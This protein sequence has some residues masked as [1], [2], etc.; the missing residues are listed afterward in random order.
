MDE[1]IRQVM[2]DHYGKDDSR[3]Y[4]PDIY[5]LIAKAVAAVLK[6]SNGS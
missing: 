2:L 1:I 3:A 5:A 6:V 4:D